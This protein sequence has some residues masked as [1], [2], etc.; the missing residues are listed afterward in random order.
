MRAF[1][2]SRFS[3]HMTRTPEGF[4]ICHSVPICRTGTQEYLPQEI[5]VEEDKPIIT[6]LRTPAEVFKP[7]AIA[8]F[9]GKPVTDEHPPVALDSS[10]CT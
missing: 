1:Y 3:P 4:L 7:A 8:S 2:G 5:G 6:A 9:E 10:R